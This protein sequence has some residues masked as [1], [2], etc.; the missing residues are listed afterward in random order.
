MKKILLI[1]IFLAATIHLYGQQESTFSQYMFNGLTLNPGYAGS[2]DYISTNAVVRD[3]WI[4][5]PGQ[6]MTMTL[7]V[8]SR[9]PSENMGLGV[10]VSSDIIGVSQTNEIGLN[11]SYFVQTGEKTRLSLGLKLALLNYSENLTELTVWDQEHIFSANQSRWLPKIG[12][13]LYFYSD[14][15]Y[16]GLSIP[17]IYVYDNHYNFNIDINESSF[18][19][20]HIYLTAGYVFTLN[21]DFKL[22]PFTLVKKSPGAPI[23]ADLNLAGVYADKFWLGAGYRFN[24][25]VMAMFSV[26]INDHFRL[27]YAYDVMNLGLFSYTKGAHEIQLGID[28][29]GSTKRIKSVRY[30]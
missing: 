15:Y 14:T 24:Q 4:D 5:Y 19:R 12:A 3:Q 1:G 8:D 10:T 6:P 16:V 28:F 30:F 23:Q 11:Y 27:G 18:Y 9:I 17:A 29:G 2:H 26:Q 7:S 25:S 22:K 21:E 20:R 13:G